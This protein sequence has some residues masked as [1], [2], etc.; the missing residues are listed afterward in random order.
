MRYWLVALQAAFVVTLALVSSRSIPFEFG[1]PM[2]AG[3]ALWSAGVGFMI[4]RNGIMSLRSETPLK[5]FRDGLL[6]EGSLFVRAFKLMLVLAVAI[7][8]H[9]WAKSMIPYVTG[10]YWADPYLA[11]VDHRIF[12]QDPWWLFRSDLL[13]PL[14]AF[15][16]VWWFAYVF[17]MQGVLAFSKADHSRLFVA[18]LVTLIFAG[19]MGQYVLPSAGPM[20]Y[21]RVGFGPRFHELVATNDPTYTLFAN[22]LWSHYQ[23]GGADL[24]TGISAMPSM[25]V[26]LAVWAIFA[27]WALWRPLAAPA[28]IYAALVW[29]DSIASGWHYATDGVVGALAAVVAWKISALDGA[30]LRLW[31]PAE[32]AARSPATSEPAAP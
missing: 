3:I 17:G 21:E 5:S 26:A 14:Y 1:R 31:R 2:M 6:S 22:Y 12:G 24:G 29:C 18:Y 19:T 27:A 13:K 4:T 9:G 32:A 20:F 7:A 10:G 15:T 30:K 28:A 11:N 8:L 16:Y 23:S 25:H